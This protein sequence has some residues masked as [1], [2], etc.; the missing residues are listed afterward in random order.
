MGPEN[1]DAFPT[2]CTKLVVHRFGDLDM[3][4]L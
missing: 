4:P 1:V 3:C 2:F